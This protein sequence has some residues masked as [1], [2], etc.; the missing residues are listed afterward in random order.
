VS[1]LRSLGQLAPEVRGWS[2]LDRI[3]ES[4]PARAIE[5]HV[6]LAIAPNGLGR[7]LKSQVKTSTRV[8][9]GSREGVLAPHRAVES[10]HRQLQEPGLPVHC[11]YWYAVLSYRMWLEHF[12]FWDVLERLSQLAQS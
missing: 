6:F 8:F 1:R 5:A 11:D 10:S 7:S 9:L 3:D 12:L 4:K 2:V